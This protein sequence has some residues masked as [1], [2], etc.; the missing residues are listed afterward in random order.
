MLCMPLAWCNVYFQLPALEIEGNGLAFNNGFH[1]H[2]MSHRQL[3]TQVIAQTADRRRHCRPSARGQPIVT[4]ATRA[5][6]S[7]ASSASEASTHMVLV[8][9]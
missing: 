8:A 7:T 1:C 3:A 6:L 2:R 4:R 9:P 5:Y